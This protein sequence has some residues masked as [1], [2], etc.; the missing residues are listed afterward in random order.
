MK[1]L[2]DAEVYISAYK[3]ASGPISDPGLLSLFKGCD[4][5]ET[6][7]SHIIKP[8]PKE[9]IANM[10]R[11]GRGEHLMNDEFP[12]A[13][14]IQ[15]K[16]KFS[17][18]GD[19][20]WAF[21]FEVVR[22]RLAEILKEAD[23]GPKGG[24]VPY[25]IFQEDRITKLEEE[26]YLLNF[27]CVKDTFVPDESLNVKKITEDIFFAEITVTNDDICLRSEAKIGCDIWHEK[28]LSDGGPFFSNRLAR[29]IID[30]DIKP[31]L[32]FSTCRVKG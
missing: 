24:L 2:K 5:A 28:K 13:C 3:A 10:T 20:F 17:L 21:G 31:D 16:K 23:L 1:K 18:V 11:H 32:R 15:N 14:A 30:A 12:L 27:D 6:E 25:T 26:F 22:G 4:W 9:V 7:L 8:A 19:L 29:Q